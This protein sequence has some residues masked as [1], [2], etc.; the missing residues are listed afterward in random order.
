MFQPIKSRWVSTNAN[1]PK[2]AMSTFAWKPAIS[3]APTPSTCQAT[4]AMPVSQTTVQVAA[5]SI[6]LLDTM[7]IS[8]DLENI[9][10]YFRRIVRQ[11]SRGAVAPAA[12]LMTWRGIQNS[13]G[14][15][16]LPTVDH[17]P[18]AAESREASIFVRPKTC[19]EPRLAIP[20][21]LYALRFDDQSFR[22]LARLLHQSGLSDYAGIINSPSFAY[23]SM[24]LYRFICE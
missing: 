4:N 5:L 21:S 10:E 17:V 18:V 20:A 14:G 16:S 2:P 3:H 1:W 6:L 23:F 8:F 15:R 19:S 9:Y 22:Q 7:L 12:L 11:P 24:A 13:G